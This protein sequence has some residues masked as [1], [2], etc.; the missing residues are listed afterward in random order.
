[1]PPAV[2][3]SGITS[4][5]S[6]PATNGALFAV[7]NGQFI[8]QLEPGT[9][10]VLD[11]IVPVAPTDGSD[12]LAFDGRY[13]YYNGAEFEGGVRIV[14]IDPVDKV[15]L[16]SAQVPME[17]IDGLAHSGAMLY[18][19]GYETGSVYALDYEEG[20]IVHQIIPDVPLY[21]GIT[22][23]G[24]RQTL[25]A[26][27]AFNGDVYEIDA[28][29]GATVNQ[30]RPTIFETVFGVAYSR[31]LEALILGSDVGSY[32]VVD[33]DDG[34]V[35]G[36]F[37][38]HPTYALAGDEAGI[39]P[40][41]TVSPSDGTVPPGGTVDVG[42]VFDATELITGTYTAQFRIFT[43]EP[44][45]QPSR[46]IPA[47][48][49]V[50]GA[51]V[52]AV[53]DTLQFPLT[54][55]GAASTRG[56]E[57]SNPGT[58][59]LTLTAFSIEGDDFRVLTEAMLRVAPGDSR[60]VPVRY[61]PT[62]SG[63]SSGTLTVSSDAGDA[64]VRLTGQAVEAPV[65]SVSPDSIR[66]DVARGHQ[67][68]RTLIVRNDGG[69]TLEWS[70]VVAHAANGTVLRASPIFS[71]AGETAAKAALKAGVGAP[72]GRPLGGSDDRHAMSAAF[73]GGGGAAAAPP[74]ATILEN[75]NAGASVVTGLIPDRFDF[76][77]GSFGM[78]IDD[79]GFDMYDGG[80]VLST[81]LAGEV[82]YTGGALEHHAAFGGTADN[83]FT[84][85]VPGLFVLAA[86]LTGVGAFEINGNLG[87]DGAGSVD[88]SI[89]QT[90][91]AGRDYQIFVKRVFDA[92]DPSVNHLVIVE[93]GAG[94]GHT[95]S[96]NT[97][98]DF[99]RVYNLTG[100]ERLYYLLYAGEDG[101]YID[102]EATLEITNAFL[103]VLGLA[104]GW[105]TLEPSAGSVEPGDSAE[106][107][108]RLDAGGLEPDLYVAEV[109]VSGN[110]LDSAAV[111]TRI[112]MDV[113]MN[114]AAESPDLPL[115]FALE[116]GFPN[117]AGASGTTIGYA[118]PRAADVRLTVY[119]AIGRQVAT[120]V[121]EGQSAGRH[122]VRFDTSVLPSGLYLY[123][124]E[125]AGFTETR[126]LLVVR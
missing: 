121:E 67:A 101:R 36:Q 74:L 22:Y 62:T 88:G 65:L 17:W 115:E 47:T 75:F 60:T 29:T 83:Y 102:D 33:P 104:P 37:S 119:D 123:R 15:R 3:L 23:G 24:S 87:A 26:L 86:D 73:S 7:W 19:L 98:D 27:N 80:N 78:Y 122:R 76:E 48:L 2:A 10:A 4:T 120:L 81:D 8:V 91:V 46:R 111:R 68:T 54:Y 64:I 40:F 52:L 89:M 34:S 106:V 93:G 94:A 113:A 44:K 103:G 30:L 12:G 1:M 61:E 118:L 66:I 99:H 57:V 55:V 20:S 18:A 96:T 71:G 82:P 6:D 79:G 11:T 124:I 25:F 28:V 126:S 39:V 117:P 77:G 63:E 32:Y 42:V 31:S 116:G 9:G 38:G 110:G 43:N 97:D 35:L 114:V 109:H 95:F 5:A 72:S 21:G 56:L 107:E 59:S 14:R 69:S 105:V 53:E 108:V 100:A 125:A 51:P 112:L 16:D 13:L 58:D 90:R 49:Q 50:S 85:K 70:A 41:V 92:F 45:P 84:Q